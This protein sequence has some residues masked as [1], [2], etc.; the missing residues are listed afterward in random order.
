MWSPC[1][2]I[3]IV[4]N[5]TLHSLEETISGSYLHISCELFNK[6]ETYFILMLFSP[7][8]RNKEKKMSFPTLSYNV[9]LGWAIQLV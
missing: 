4:L 2:S 3:G 9:W 1:Y 6:L 8:L 5:V 7:T